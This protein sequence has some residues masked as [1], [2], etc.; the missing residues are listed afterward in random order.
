LAA[1]GDSEYSLQGTSFIWQKQKV[2]RIKIKKIVGYT[3]K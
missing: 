2:L 1:L 3:L